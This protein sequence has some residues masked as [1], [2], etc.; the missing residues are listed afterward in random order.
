MS[1]RS[2]L[3][4]VEQTAVVASVV[5]DLRREGGRHLAEFEV[6]KIKDCVRRLQKSWHGQRMPA[7]LRRILTELSLK[8]SYGIKQSDRRQTVLL[9]ADRLEPW[10]AK[11]NLIPPTEQATAPAPIPAPAPVETAEPFIVIRPIEHA[12]NPRH[13]PTLAKPIQIGMKLET[14]DSY[15]IARISAQWGNATAEIIATGTELTRAKAD[16]S[17]GEFMAMVR[18]RLPFG[19]RTAQMLMAIYHNPALANAKNSAHLPPSW[20]ALHALAGIP[21]DILER[22][23]RAGVITPKLTR[24]EIITKVLEQEPPPKNRPTEIAA[25]KR[26]IATA[27]ALTA[28]AA[29]THENIKQELAAAQKR[30]KELEEKQA[31]AAKRLLRRNDAGAIRAINKAAHIFLFYAQGADPNVVPPN[32]VWRD[33]SDLSGPEWVACRAWAAAKAAALVIPYD[34]SNPAQQHEQGK[35]NW[36]DQ[37]RTS[38]EWVLQVE[39]RERE[40]EILELRIRELEADCQ[41]GNDAPLAGAQESELASALARIAELEA[42]REYR[43]PSLAGAIRSVITASRGY[44]TGAAVRADRD[45]FDEIRRTLVERDVRQTESFLKEMRMDI[46]SKGKAR[47]APAPDMQA[48]DTGELAQA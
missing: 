16:L 27:H 28:A 40:I 5:G 32:E 39:A 35:K 37:H 4:A 10:A 23:I 36:L 18:K 44:P 24:A 12:H 38:E 41:H 29:C 47:E 11:A 26:E 25:L 19:Q 48:S 13:L 8:K 45:V 31:H 46:W 3:T 42:E 21:W 22:K 14:R 2:K 7:P 15:W 34:S 6:D 43:P 30:L 17:H 20:T 1:K 33:E 9:Q